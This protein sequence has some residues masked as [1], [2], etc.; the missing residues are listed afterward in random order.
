MSVVSIVEGYAELASIPI[1]LRRLGV[2]AAP[3]FRVKRNL[4]VK[5]GE[6]ERA[7]EAVVRVRSSPSAVLVLLDADDDC[8]A[9]LAPALLE[10]ARAVT[11]L[12]VSMVFAMREIEAWFLGGIEPASC[13]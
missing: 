2:D 11:I 5:P 7:L 3:A 9:Q 12:P 4:V 6:L 10:R 8:P 1:L 13:T